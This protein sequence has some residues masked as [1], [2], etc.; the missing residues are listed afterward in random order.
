[1]V[2][3]RF[4]IPSCQHTL[5]LV[6]MKQPAMLV[7]SMWQGIPGGFQS[8][9]SKQLRPSVQTLARNWILL[10]IT[11]VSLE[12]NPSTFWLQ[13]MRD[14]KPEGSVKNCAWIPDSQKLGDNKCGI[15]GLPRWLSG[16]E[17]AC[18]AGDTGDLGSIPRS[19]RSPGEG[20]GN[21]LQY[22]CLE[23]PTE[24]GAWRATVHGVTKRWT[25]LSTQHIKKKK[26]KPSP[27]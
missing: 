13:S 19:G 25:R 8:R 26:P 27:T 20:N 6:S 1:M 18:D 2:V 3:P 12:V 22:S 10:T 7:R 24:R 21:P 16:K 11:W 15:W 4:W 23:N 5:L 9:A 17:S 14:P